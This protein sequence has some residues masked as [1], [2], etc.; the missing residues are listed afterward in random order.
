M[1]DVTG[2]IDADRGYEAGDRLRRTL[3][4]HERS[5]HHLRRYARSPG[6]LDWA[7]RPDP[8]RTYAG[9]PAV[10]LPLLADGLATPYADLYRPGA[11][12]PRPLDL[13]GVAL[14]FELAFGL[15]AWKQYK[16]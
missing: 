7:N 9:A 2:R 10:D 6:G 15:S 1:T 12:A 11:V 3:A 8:Y 16:G 14:L 4:Y 5:K 13:D